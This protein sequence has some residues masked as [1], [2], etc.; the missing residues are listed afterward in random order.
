MFTLKGN[1]LSKE[2]QLIGLC[3]EK[4]VCVVFEAQTEF[5]SIN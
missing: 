1:Y 5:L 2:H 4:A 3:N